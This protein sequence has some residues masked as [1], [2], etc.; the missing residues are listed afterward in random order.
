MP[1]GGVKCLLAQNSGDRVKQISEF[2]ASLVYRA[3]SRAGL[4]REPVS[5]DKTNKQTNKKEEKL[6]GNTRIRLDL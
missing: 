5:K 3:S 6:F 2:M 1:G 4:R